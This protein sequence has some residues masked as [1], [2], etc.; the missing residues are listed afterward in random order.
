MKGVVLAAPA[1]R[2]ARGP[3]ARGA[4]LRRPG[5][6][7][8]PRGVRAALPARGGP[9]GGGGPGRRHG[10][11]AALRRR[12][13]TGAVSSGPT[14][15][16]SRRSSHGR[17]RPAAR[18]R[19]APSRPRPRPPSTGAT[20]SPRSRPGSPPAATPARLG[21]EVADPVRLAWPASSARGDEIRGACLAADPFG[22]VLTSVRA[23]D[24]GAPRPSSVAVAAAG[25]PLRADLRRGRARRAAGAPRQLAGGSSSRCA[26]GAR[27]ERLGAYRDVPVAVRMA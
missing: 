19:A 16:S 7:A 20:C 15:G 1:R 9:P 6:R 27:P 5:G 4:G 26:K 11:A 17:A 18:D 8:P 3:L 22:N 2:A 25:G 23:A 12:S 24:L 10:A 14:T 21:P 13:P